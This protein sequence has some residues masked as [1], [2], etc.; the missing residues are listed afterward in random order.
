MSPLENQLD[1]LCHDAQVLL[2]SWFGP[3][4]QL[5]KV[6]ATLSESDAVAWEIHVS[7]PSG[8]EHGFAG[9]DAAQALRNLE[10]FGMH[11]IA[12]GLAP[13][14]TRKQSA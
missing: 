1:D 10:R 8:I 7:D 13:Q 9:C 6:S 3:P 11:V 4:S 5:L 12:H 14:P 2:Q